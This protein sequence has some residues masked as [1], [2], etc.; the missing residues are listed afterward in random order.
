[1]QQ[2]APPDEVDADEDRCDGQRPEDRVSDAAVQ[3]PP[4]ACADEP[5]RERLGRLRETV[6][7]VGE[8]GEQLQQDG[9]DGQQCPILH[10]GRCAGEEGVDGYDAERADDD[11]AVDDQKAP[12]RSHVEDCRPVDA[13][14]ELPIVGHDQHGGQRHAE[15]LGDDRAVTDAGDA[16]PAAEG[17]EPRTA[18]MDDVLQNGDPHGDA[19]VLHPDE[20]AVEAEEHDARRYGPDAGVEVF[21]DQFVAV[22]GPD[23]R[24]AERVLQQ[25]D[26]CA[27]YGRDE[28][29]ARQRGGAFAVVL[30]AVG[31]RRQSARAHAQEG[32]VPVDEVEDRNA[33][34]QRSD[35]ARGVAA[36]QIAGD[37]RAGDAHDGDGDVGNDVRKREPQDFPIHK[38]GV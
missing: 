6:G 20:P 8:E 34:G 13:R 24:L 28:Q 30:R 19:G 31:L 26:Q 25:Q 29:R 2:V 23:R 37:H 5:S 12:D 18:D 1:M 3:R 33:D 21:G 32:A 4:V 10:A 16:H 35:R 17:E 22:H 11:V 14:D 9:V 36:A 27:Q 15:I 38:R 7:H